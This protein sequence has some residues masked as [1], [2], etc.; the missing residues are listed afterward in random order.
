MTFAHPTL[1]N[2]KICFQIRQRDAGKGQ[3]EDGV[4]VRVIAEGEDGLEAE[5]GNEDG[6]SGTAFFDDNADATPIGM[7]EQVD[8]RPVSASEAFCLV[9]V[10]GNGLGGADAL[11]N[12]LAVQQR[13]AAKICP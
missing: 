8:K 3:G 10:V 13:V 12:L 1:H 7:G 6:R 4:Q 2:L 9:T 11:E 5:V